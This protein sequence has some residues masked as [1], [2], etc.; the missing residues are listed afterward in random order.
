MLDAPSSGSRLQRI[1]G[2]IPPWLPV[3]AML[4][5]AC[6][7]VAV[8]YSYLGALWLNRHERSPLALTAVREW[9]NK[10]TGI[11]EDFGPLGIGL[12]LI[13]AGYAMAAAA[14]RAGVRITAGL[15][16]VVPLLWCAIALSA[17]VL[18]LGGETLT[19]PDGAAV[20]ADGVAA[21]LALLGAIGGTPALVALAWPVQAGLLFGVLLV[22]SAALLRR[23]AWLAVLLQLG[24]IVVISAVAAEVTVPPGIG[25]EPRPVA[26]V[27]VFVTFCV[28]GELCWLTRAERMATWLAVLLGTAALLVVV[29]VE[30][31]YPELA[32]WWYPLTGV[33]A[34]LL[35]LL[36]LAV[37]C[38]SLIVRWLATRSLPILL[39]V[40]VAGYGVLGALADLAGVAIA[41]LVALVAT[42]GASELLYR[43]VLRPLARLTSRQLLARTS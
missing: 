24:G 14:W 38:R 26:L 25:A 22:A 9:I 35:T 31:F 15:A 16:W 3:E 33:Y 41:F 11:G 42:A 40:G 12:L 10:P 4:P 29:A 19:Y 34:V 23:F 1:V 2:P 18:A 27:A 6:G 30:R 43:I 21:N 8:C 37:P 39:T 20:S 17:G 36:T 5:A 13:V 28:L 7:I 32:P